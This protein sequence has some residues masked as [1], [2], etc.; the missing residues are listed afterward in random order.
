[1]IGRY[2]ARLLL[3]LAIG[4]LSV[5]STAQQ[6]EQT[7]IPEATADSTLDA[8]SDTSNTKPDNPQRTML[9]VVG[10][11]G[12]TEY[13][14]SFLKQTAV[15]EKAAQENG[16]RLITIKPTVSLD[17]Q[18][19]EGDEVLNSTISNDATT[20]NLGTDIPAPSESADS[21][22]TESESGTLD[23]FAERVVIAAA[24]GT[25]SESPTTD[26]DRLV[27]TLREV[28]SSDIHELWVVL[29]G[30]GTFDGRTAKFNLVGPDFSGAELAGWLEELPSELPV[31]IINTASASGGMLKNL[32]RKNRVVVTATKS[33]A[34][35]NVTRFGQFLTDSI[36]DPQADLDKDGSISL[37]EAFLLAA[38]RT[39]EFY[40]SD[41]RLAT[42]HALIDDNGDGRGTSAAWF[43]GIRVV[44]RS[45]DGTEPDGP[46]AHQFFI[47]NPAQSET[48]TA[49]QQS[50]RSRLELEIESLIRLKPNLPPE[51]YYRQLEPL[52][53]SLSLLSNPP[54]SSEPPDQN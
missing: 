49:E 27:E 45:R 53:L 20:K 34:E 25:E 54:P 6:T 2:L 7:A 18:S 52:L 10:A 38:R 36:R 15:W 31:V 37:L 4:L 40:D 29:I 16:F 42:E 5:P 13:G 32:S 1:M 23:S 50:E 21:G 28:A 44:G 51:E 3:I 11:A 43:T 12:K 30:H 33:G 22:L 35:T 17:E 14:E 8:N 46:R 26:R 24:K 9:V 47:A 19:E 39:Q 41:S 48:L